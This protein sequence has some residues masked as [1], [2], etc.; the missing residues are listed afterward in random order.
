MK[1][2]DPI[3]KQVEKCGGV[4]GIRVSIPPDES[5]AI[6]SGVYQALA[7]PLR[8]KILTLLARQPLCVCIIKELVDIPDSK[9]S[10][11]LGILKDTGLIEG[12]REGNWIIYRATRLGKRYRL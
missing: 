12:N 4:E 3:K 6:Q 7:D 11:H 9:L 1:I 8:L 10:Y 2:P 5:L